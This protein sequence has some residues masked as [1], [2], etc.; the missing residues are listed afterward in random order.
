MN[1]PT[2]VIKMDYPDPDIIRVEDTYYMIS[3]TMHFMPG[4]VILRSYD[5]VNWEIAGY[6][7]DTLEETPQERMEGETSIYGKGMWAASLRYHKGSFYVLFGVPG[8]ASYLY[9]AKE[10]GGP[11]SRRKLE[12]SYGYLHDASLLF[13]DDD[14][15]YIAFGQSEIRLTEWMPD[16]SGIRE[17]G[18]D[19]V[20]VS[21]K[22]QVILGHEGSHL[23]RINGKYYLF[24]IHWPMERGR[25][26]R[27]QMCFIADSLEGE[28]EEHEVL[29]D[30][31]GFRNQGVAQGGIVDTP[32][33]R[34]YAMLFQDHG[35]VGR[36][37]VLVPV[38]WRGELPV[39]GREGRVPAVVSLRS[40]RPDYS[41]EP[42]YTSDSFPCLR[43][44]Q[45]KYELKRQ[46]QWN[47]DPDPGLWGLKEKGGL[48]IRTDKV[49]SNVLQ[50]KNT[51]TQRML[52]PR[53]SAEVTVD[54]SGLREGDYAGLCALQ[55][56]Y[57][58]IGITRNLSSYYLVVV[59]RALQDAEMSK[60]TA[61]D[62]MPGR[63]TQRVLLPGPVVQVRMS[64]NFS[65]MID[66]VEFAWKNGGHW[67]TAGEKH[68]LYFRLDH[69]T[70][71]RF[72]LA[73]FSSRESG[74]EA[75]FRDFV[76]QE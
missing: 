10:V 24:T 59:S 7:Y 34:W 33:G 65:D 27:T 54:G 5:L 31:M 50:A 35:A 29:S 23:Y 73:M 41:Y 67:E 46:W 69:F 38:T 48:W 47:H 11:W 64:A 53:C 30:D 18:L 61:Q 39:L 22:Q 52:Y 74:G 63:L 43:D 12:S 40:T 56:C 20:I 71:C 3:T 62:Y 66:T 13:D 4:G 19:R 75:V 9:T 37:P 72:G 28:F 26:R 45:G 57:C 49:C 6:V 2:P 21:E 60:A 44:W 76:Y 55:G 15:V 14:R 51:L 1:R 36:M 68:K 32:D 16:F 17:G 70:G 58:M 42:L 8:S 25:D